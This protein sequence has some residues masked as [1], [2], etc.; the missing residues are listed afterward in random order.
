LSER[1][2]MTDSIEFPALELPQIRPISNNT[3]F[4]DRSPSFK[5]GTQIQETIENI[6]F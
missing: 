6:R 5:H 2:K 4:T 3:A 1:K